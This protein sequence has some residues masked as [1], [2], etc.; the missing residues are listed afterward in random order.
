MRAKKLCLIAQGS[1]RASLDLSLNFFAHQG[2][3]LFPSKRPSEDV[4]ELCSQKHF[5]VWN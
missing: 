2:S 1:Q 4:S 5:G 3:A